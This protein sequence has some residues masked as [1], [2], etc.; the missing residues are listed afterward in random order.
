MDKLAAS[1][2][3]LLDELERCRAA[4]TRVEG[5]E[6]ENQ[7]LAGELES[8][9]KQRISVPPVERLVN[10]T[11]GPTSEPPSPTKSDRN[12]SDKAASVKYRI[13]VP[14]YNAVVANYSSMK[15]AKIKLEEIRAA[16]KVKIRKWSTGKQEDERKIARRDTRIKRQKEEIQRLQLLLSTYTG[17]RE[18]SLIDEIGTPLPTGFKDIQIPRKRLDNSRHVEDIEN[19]PGQDETDVFLPDHRRNPDLPTIVQETEVDI[20]IHHSSSTNSDPIAEALLESKGI[21]QEPY[22]SP[23]SITFVSARSVSKSKGAKNNQPRN[24]VKHESHGSSSP[25]MQA[26]LT[27]Q[28]SMDLDDIGEKVDTPRKRKRAIELNRKLSVLTSSSPISSRS[29]SHSHDHGGSTEAIES[30][31]D[32]TPTARKISVLQPRSVNTPILPRTSDARTY[33]KRKIADDKAVSSL[34]EDGE[35]S[36]S[37]SVENHNFGRLDN[38]LNSPSPR[39]QAITPVVPVPFVTHV[40]SARTLAPSRLANEVGRDFSPTK[41]HIASCVPSGSNRRGTSAVPSSKSTSPAKTNNTGRLLSRNITPRVSP[42]PERPTSRGILDKSREPSP[43]FDGLKNGPSTAAKGSPRLT[44]FFNSKPTTMTPHKHTETESS[45]KTTPVTARRDFV[46]RPAPSSRKRQ[47]RL[48]PDDTEELDVRPEH[49]PLRLRPVQSL[50]FGDFKINPN[51]NQGYDYAFTEVVRG[52]D[53]RKCLTAC[54]KPECCGNAFRAIVESMRD[55]NKPLTASQEEEDTAI[56]GEYMGRNAYKIQ[57]MSKAERDEIILQAKTRNY[58][59]ANG[60]HRHAFEKPSS[61][62]GFWRAEM[63]STQ[64]EI[65]DR[66]KAREKDRA[67][68]EERYRE[69]MRKGGKYLFRDE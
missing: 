67:V 20:E 27:F 55:P 44:A 53:A 19:F 52:K 33:K 5:L 11:P 47:F 50:T 10:L 34:L 23:N 41:A 51:Y 42:A 60:K 48:G 56:L 54:T 7:R 62:P 21:K 26:L 61:P 15:E 69:A 36:N 3:R 32:R 16:D 68:V 57:N 4:S 45:P 24:I 22:S 30:P 40:R 6:K 31:S 8:A 63:P 25:L 49:E 1:N 29:R 14:K 35:L 28:D 64:E 18:P 43:F 37:E 13:L 39:K 17:K 38:L 58:A 59:N 66:A 12:T 2:S 9:L 46:D 65:S